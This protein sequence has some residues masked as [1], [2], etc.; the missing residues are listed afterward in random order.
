MEKKHVS[1]SEKT[2]LEVVIDHL[3]IAMP[4]CLTFVT[5]KSIDIV[6]VMFVGHLGPQFLSAAGLASVTANVT[7]NSMLIG[8][9]GPLTTLASQ[10]YGA[11]D[12]KELNVSLQRTI[13]ILSIF[14][15]I[16]VSVLWLFS[17][18]IMRYLGQNHHIAVASGRF[19]FYLIPSLWARAFS[20][21][22]QNWL[23]A[24]GKTKAMAIIS[25]VLALLHPLLCYLFIFPMGLGYLGAAAAVSSSRFLELA[26]SALYLWWSANEETKSILSWNSACL[27]DWGPF[28]ALG[29]PNL[30]MMTEWWASEIVIFLSGALNN[31]EAQVSAMSIYQS[32]LAFCFM[33]P[34]GFQVSGSTIVGNALGAADAATAKSASRVAPSLTLVVTISMAI[35]L[36]VWKH[37]CCRLFTS[38]KEVVA[39][40]ESLMPVLA[41]YVVVDGMQTSLTG[42]IKGMGKQKIAG[43][44]V[45]IAYYAMGLPVGIVLTFVYHWGI[46]GLCVGTL[47]GTVAH[48]A[49]YWHVVYV[50]TDWELEIQSSIVRQQHSTDNL[51]DSMAAI[52]SN[53][54]LSKYPWHSFL[55]TIKNATGLSTV[56]SFNSNGSLRVFKTREPSDTAYELV[57]TQPEE[58]KETANELGTGESENV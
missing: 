49:M 7:G 42:V 1:A 51:K 19:L 39:L 54:L 22:I 30:M 58:L 26:M 53:G 50:Q 35:G 9:S 27:E 24:Q 38:D 46:Y 32:I 20:T 21:S 40:V 56:K 4:V 36:I 25:T 41:C 12:Y 6:S 37:L 29:L 5:K 17:E 28:L 11:K 8:L 16:P 3:R 33:F 10:A 13:I 34:S 44:I 52:N 18:N 45:M 14:V 57:A 2:T 55:R 23:Y 47:L 48:L 15:C 31:P 43:P